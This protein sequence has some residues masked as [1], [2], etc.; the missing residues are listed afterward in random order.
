MKRISAFVLLV[1]LVWC[2]SFLSACNDDD[3][4]NDDNLGDENDTSDDDDDTGDDDDTNDDDSSLTDDDTGDDD[5]DDDDT[6]DDDTGDDDAF[7]PDN[8]SDEFGVF[9]AMGGD[10]ANPGTMAA[11]KRTVEAGVELAAQTDKVVFIAEGAY[12]ESVNATASLY[13]GY[14]VGT[15]QRNVITHPTALAHGWKTPLTIIGE[16][17]RLIVIDG[18]TITGGKA[19]NSSYGARLVDAHAI[20]NR[21]VLVSLPISGMT[22]GESVGISIVDSQVELHD[23]LIVSGGITCQGYCVADLSSSMAVYSANSDL[24]M[25]RNRA[26]TGPHSVE[27]FAAGGYGLFAEGG[28]LSL[29]YNLFYSTANPLVNMSVTLAACI[30]DCEEV[31]L[32]ANRLHSFRSLGSYALYL[33]RSDEAPAMKVTA[34]NNLFHGGGMTDYGGLIEM[35]GAMELILL[36]NIIELHG[37]GDD[38]TGLYAYSSTEPSTITLDNNHFDVPDGAVLLHAGGEDYYTLEELHACAWTGCYEAADNLTGDP[39]LRGVYNPHLT[40]AS[41]C[42]DAG[43]DPTSWYDGP[44]IH[45]DYDGDARPYGAGWDIGMDEYTAR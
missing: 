41:P 9:V 11:P 4:D 6:G 14:Q 23:N 16:D 45:F 3:D 26:I 39:R 40:A 15:W 32:I 7:D 13:G 33:R 36:N 5:I 21:N 31:T 19:L 43:L 25:V 24:T 34:I 30:A 35:S 10:D 42:I 37:I 29:A 2:F 17:D 44:E 38:V 18:L 12:T 20:L 1:G 8:P 27:A 22:P 28:R